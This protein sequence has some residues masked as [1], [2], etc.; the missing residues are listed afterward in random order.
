MKNNPIKIDIQEVKDKN[1]STEI[2]GSLTEEKKTEIKTIVEKNFED[3]IEDLGKILDKVMPTGTS[4]I[5]RDN[6]Y[7]LKI[8]KP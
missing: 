7:Q 2:T 1:K 4:V 5:L 8:T 6:G 3:S